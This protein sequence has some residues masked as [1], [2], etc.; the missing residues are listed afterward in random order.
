[1]WFMFIGLIIAIDTDVNVLSLHIITA[2]DVLYDVHWI[3]IA[4]IIV[5]E[6]LP[7]VEQKRYDT[8]LFDSL[9]L[10]WSLND[11]QIRRNV[12]RLLVQQD[13]R[14]QF[15]SGREFDMS[16]VHIVQFSHGNGISYILN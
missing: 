9:N 16:N 11:Q 1:M 13:D 14:N 15:V 2:L 4:D 7:L 10:H 6:W 8:I 3:N 5:G 12:F